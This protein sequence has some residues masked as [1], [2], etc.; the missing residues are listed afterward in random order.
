MEASTFFGVARAHLAHR[1]GIRSY[2]EGI[3]K[4]KDRGMAIVSGCYY[5]CETGISETC[6]GETFPGTSC[7]SLPRCAREREQVLG[8]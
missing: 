7:D 2:H 3:P 5:A 1:F 6:V 4:P 8:T